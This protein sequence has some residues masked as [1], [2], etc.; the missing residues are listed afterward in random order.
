MKKFVPP[1][2]WEFRDIFTCMTFN[3]LPEHSS[4]DH[5]IDLEE[6]FIPQREKIYHLSPQ[7]QRALDEFL[8]ESLS[9]GQ[10]RW[11]SSPSSALK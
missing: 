10:I 5:Q 11:S 8:E 1:H 2:F 4:F 6:M 3:S 9:S 7:E